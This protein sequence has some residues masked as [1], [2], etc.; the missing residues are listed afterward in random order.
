MN[1][2]FFVLYIIKPKVLCIISAENIEYLANRIVV[3]LCQ[4]P[5]DKRGD[6][7]TKKIEN[8]LEYSVYGRFHLSLYTLCVF[9]KLST[10]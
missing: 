3:A 8:K 5:C 2:S 7:D 1:L 6:D 9:F 4:C 10:W